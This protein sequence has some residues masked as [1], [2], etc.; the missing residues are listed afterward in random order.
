MQHEDLVSFGRLIVVLATRT[1]ASLQNIPDS[2]EYISKFY[3]ENLQSLLIF[4]FGKQSPNKTIES[5]VSIISPILMD[6]LNSTFQQS[7]MLQRELS[8][9]LEN[10]RLFRLLTKLG[11]INERPE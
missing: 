8:K 9:E 3:S 1:T 5:L 2:F 10:A 7:D 4:L 11:F 6:E